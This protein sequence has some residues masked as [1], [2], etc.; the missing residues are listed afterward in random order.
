MSDSPTKSRSPTPTVSLVSGGL[1]GLI[2]AMSLQPLDLLKTRLQ[3]QHGA[4]RPSL[5]DEVRKVGNWRELWRGVVP[6]TLRTSVGAGLYFTTLSTV[7]D[8]VARYKAK[9]GGAAYTTSASSVLPRLS[10]AENLSIGFLARAAV[11]YVTMPIT[12]IKTRYESDLYHYNS[13]A[14]AVRGTYYDGAAHGRIANFFRGSLTT[15]ARDC[16]YAGL[17]V[18]FY[19]AC[20]YQAAGPGSVVNSASAFVAAAAATTVTAPFDAIK[21]RLQL[22][23]GLSF[24][25]A[26]AQLCKEPGG[27]RNLFRGL[28]LRLSRKGVSAA[29]SWCVYE[30]LIKSTW[31]SN[32]LARPL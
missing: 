22:Q 1:A 16:P 3:Q 4:H 13:M 27:P 26:T 2:S 20:K 11:G 5:A 29:I 31:V 21:T 30:E 10:A 24:V 6:S 28:S 12:V 14:Q 19:E 15:L 25:G 9:H 32:A 7:R 17:Y 23:P 18:W 8:W